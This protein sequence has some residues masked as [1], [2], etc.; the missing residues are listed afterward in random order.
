MSKAFTKE[1]DFEPEAEADETD[2]LLPEGAKNYVTPAGLESL[3]AELSRIELERE[4]GPARE[5]LRELVRRARYL[6]KRIETAEPVEPVAGG[7]ETVVFGSRVRVKDEE[8]RVR[9]YQIVG[10]DETDP[11]AGKVSWLSPVAQALLGARVGDAVTLRT[12]GGE[13]ELEVVGILRG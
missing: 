6:Q 11:K 12:P 13:E 7:S 4:S 2:L 10:V 8:G 5:R 3:R 9:A 1:S